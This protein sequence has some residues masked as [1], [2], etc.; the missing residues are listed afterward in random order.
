MEPTKFCLGCTSYQPVSDFY[1]R[2][3]SADGLQARC[4]KCD[5]EVTRANKLLAR[6]GINVDQYDAMYEAQGGLCAIC[7]APPVIGRRL[8]VDHNH[9]TL[10]V[11]D[12][13][14]DGCNLGLGKMNDSLEL[15]RAAVAYLERHE[16]G[17]NIF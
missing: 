2:K 5:N 10:A 8:S 9:D 4:K 1:G 11:R 3:A 7:K 17:P 12:L 13:L 15:L 14:C 16:I 6:Y